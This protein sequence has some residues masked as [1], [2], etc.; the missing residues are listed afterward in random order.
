[1][2]IIVYP[3]YDNPYQ[4][5]LYSEIESR[6]IKYSIQYFYA[7]NGFTGYL[8]L[9][10]ILLF[11]RISGYKIFHLHWINFTV[12]TPIFTKY[13]SYI[14]TLFFLSYVKIL[15]YKL[16]WT[17]HNITPHEKQ[18][19]NDLYITKYL[20]KIA[21]ALIVHSQT[22]INELNNLACN[23]AKTIIIPLGNYNGVYKNTITKTQAR[24]I[25]GIPD[26][27]FVY[28]Y[29][30][31]IREYKG[32]DLLIKKFKEI[33]E[34]FND[35]FL[36]IAGQSIDQIYI[37]YLKSLIPVSNVLFHPESIPD[38]KL[39]IYFNAC[40]IVV[41]PFRKVTTTSS[42][43][44]A[45]AFRKPVIAPRI[46]NISDYPIDTGIYY[47][48]NNLKG[49][50]DSLIKSYKMKSKL[51]LIGKKAYKYSETLSWKS[52]ADKTINVYSNVLNL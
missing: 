37:K 42:I 20:C 23:I 1:M 2:N 9:F 13:F 30:G 33:N 32:V 52:V 8:D 50:S 5:L 26:N 31:Y 14:N 12:N 51:S 19:I 41:M 24:K 44:T 29:F 18:T 7:P 49:L 27:K 43:L 6:N 45:F 36:I 17:V 10:V 25:L 39:Q 16:V 34:E 40:D 38:E 48:Q 35:S 22:T 3:R 28:L 21:D 4:H 47:L 15:N 46:G 11:K